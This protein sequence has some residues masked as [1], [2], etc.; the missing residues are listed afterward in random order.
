MT[1]NAGCEFG[2]NNDLHE[3]NEIGQHLGASSSFTE[4]PSKQ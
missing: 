2:I 1:I 4:I 3:D